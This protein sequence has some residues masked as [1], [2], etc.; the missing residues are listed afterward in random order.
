MLWLD[1]TY[2]EGETG[3][4]TKRGSCGTDSG[5]PSDVE[6][7]V[8]NASVVFSNI[9][10]GPIGSTF[11]AGDSGSGSGNDGGS[12]TGNGGS[13]DDNGSDDG[14]DDTG[15]GGDD[16]GNGGNT[17]GGSDSGSDDEDDSGSGSGGDSSA[18]ATRWGQCGG[19]NWTGPTKCV[20]GTTCQKQNDWYYQCL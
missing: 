14:G 16:N 18:T 4:G 1:S 2:P 3:P 7:E 8:P 10:F 19:L 15:S 9:K 12:D 13:D 5:V 6:K 11:A 17:G 20:S